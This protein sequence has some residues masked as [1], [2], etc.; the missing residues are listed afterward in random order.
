MTYPWYLTQD[1]GILRKKFQFIQKQEDDR[2]REATSELVG[3]NSAWSLGVSIKPF[4]DLRNRYVNIMPYEKTRVHLN[5]LEGNDYINASYVKV[6][7]P[8][9]SLSPGYYIA[10][11]GP[12]RHTYTQFWQMCYDECPS[13]NIVI[14]MVTP[15]SEHGREKCY[16]YWPQK[17]NDFEKIDIP[18]I[19]CPTKS[20][21]LYKPE[22]M[23]TFPQGLTIEFIEQK[24]YE[25]GQYTLTN[26]RLVNNVTNEFK[27]VHHFY[28][29]QWR[30]MS[31]PQ[32]II[33]IMQ[34]CRHSHSLNS[35][36][37]P[38]IVHCSA[39]VGRSGTFIALDHLIH[40]TSDFA[41]NGNGV[42]DDEIYTKDLIEQIV[43]QLRSQRM[44]MVQM[45]DQFRF[46]YHAG[47]YLKDYIE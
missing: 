25:D 15:L 1:E 5:V 8:H 2:L 42:D 10:T 29:D 6:D 46:I 39:G 38:I 23:S 41:E 4:N 47:K 13:D 9:Q 34:L 43:L 32:E 19:Q 33:P 35:N 22:E 17:D 26:L 18:Q 28:F 30:D 3:K 37:N 24:R 12:T 21:P 45:N 27:T 40:D 20:D 14:V 36:G 7:V 44:K 31:K 16:P 11:Q